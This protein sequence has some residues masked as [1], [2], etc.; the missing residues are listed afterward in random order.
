MQ[1]VAFPLASSRRRRH[2]CASFDHDL[3]WRL[4]LIILQIEQHPPGIHRSLL[5]LRKRWLERNVPAFSLG[6]G[7]R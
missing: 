5:Q 4:D 2:T 7:V 1:L 6:Q 3:S